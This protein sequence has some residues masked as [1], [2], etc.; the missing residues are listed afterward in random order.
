MKRE[1]FCHSA[2][3]SKGTADANRDRFCAVPLRR[4]SIEDHIEW[5]EKVASCHFYDLLS[6]LL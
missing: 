2:L 4:C 3:C 5:V 1:N 6:T